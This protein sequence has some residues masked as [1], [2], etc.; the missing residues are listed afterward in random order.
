MNLLE[1]IREVLFHQ[2]RKP[3][4]EYRESARVIIIMRNEICTGALVGILEFVKC[5]VTHAAPFV[6]QGSLK[7]AFKEKKQGGDDLDF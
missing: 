7:A 5:E 6:K 3:I 4:V 1:D 2:V